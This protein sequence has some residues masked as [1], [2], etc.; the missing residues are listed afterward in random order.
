VLGV[1]WVAIA[2]PPNP[3]PGHKKHLAARCAQW[4]V[5]VAGWQPGVETR[6]ISA[7]ARTREVLLV[8]AATRLYVS[9]ATDLPALGPEAGGRSRW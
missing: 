4:S 7:L 8:H 2:V 9:W 1:G 5:Q 6:G 3:L